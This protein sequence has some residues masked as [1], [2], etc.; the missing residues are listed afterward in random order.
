MEK[1]PPVKI[2]NKVV[3]KSD[4][5]QY[6]RLYLNKKLNCILH[7]SEKCKQIEKIVKSLYWLLD[8]K[9]KLSI[10]SEDERKTDN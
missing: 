3:S 10:K 8:A 4:A 5:V 1:Y 2:N 7:I 9:S 6:L